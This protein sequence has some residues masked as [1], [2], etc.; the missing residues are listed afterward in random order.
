MTARAAGRT[1]AGIPLS[2][3]CLFTWAA[4]AEMRMSG[5][6][7]IV[8]DER[9]I[10]MAVRDTLSREGH[11]AVTASNGEEAIRRCKSEPFDLLITDLK[12]PGM[13]G[14]DLIRSVRSIHP[15]IR[16]ILITAYGSAESAIE[17]LRLGVS[18]YMVKP[19]RLSE[20]RL[21]AGRLLTQ[22]EGITAAGASTPPEKAFRYF[23][24]M[25][26]DNSIVVEGAHAPA[27]DKDAAPPHDAVRIAVRALS[28]YAAKVGAEFD[29]AAAAEAISDTL[30]F[31]HLGPVAL[32]CTS[33]RGTVH[34]SAVIGM[35][36][37]ELAMQPHGQVCKNPPAGSFPGLRAVVDS[38]PDGD[39][40]PSTTGVLRESRTEFLAP[41][42]QSA[43]SLTLNSANLDLKSLVEGVGRAARAAGLNTER[44]NELVAAVNEVVLNAIEHAY[45]SGNPGKV[46]IA[47]RVTHN[48]IVTT[49]KDFGKGFDPP[50]TPDGG[51]FATLKRLMDRVAVES[52]PGAGTTVHLAKA[53]A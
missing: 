12:M 8:D 23:F 7:L 40:Q 2:S 26:Q 14:L 45:G 53:L 19:F 39:S 47:C 32:T 30:F 49:V 42:E 4:T 35:T 22:P 33:T 29:P 37:A 10:R 6:I 44:T 34:R 9:T 27:G 5:K 43:Y 38:P 36:R 52:A 3:G 13:T 11:L 21:T 18:D 15:Q 20:L 46:E 51:G 28:Q 48:E 16:T 17:A 1:A 50:A 24:N 31:E 41:P 25:G